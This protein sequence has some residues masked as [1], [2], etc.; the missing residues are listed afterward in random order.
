[1]PALKLGPLAILKT[2]FERGGDG[3]G[4]KRRELNFPDAFERCVGQVPG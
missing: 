1:M 4:G 2:A 3:L